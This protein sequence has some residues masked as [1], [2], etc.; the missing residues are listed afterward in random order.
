MPAN[1]SL[2]VPENK[3]YRPW[4]WFIF[5]TRPRAVRRLKLVRTIQNEGFLLCFFSQ[6]VSTEKRHVEHFKKGIKSGFISLTDSCT[7]HLQEN[8]QQCLCYL[9]LSFENH[10][11]FENPSFFSRS[12]FMSTRHPLGF[13]PCWS[14]A[15]TGVKSTWVQLC[16]WGPAGGH[17]SWREQRKPGWEDKEAAR[18]PR[19]PPCRGLS[20]KLVFGTPSLRTCFLVETCRA[21]QLQ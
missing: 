7:Y 17:L 2:T 1:V 13:S 8:H 18:A 20:P 4:I 11:S 5:A 15:R 3:V 14:P 6:N 16:I 12:S 10:N 21:Y 9:Y 19:L